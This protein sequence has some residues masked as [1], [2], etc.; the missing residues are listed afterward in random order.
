MRLHS[1][2]TGEKA[3]ALRGSTLEAVL[4]RFNR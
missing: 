2:L 3:R 1:S 4:L